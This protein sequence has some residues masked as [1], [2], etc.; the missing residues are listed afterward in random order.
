MEL[1][2]RTIREKSNLDKDPRPSVYNKDLSFMIL[3]VTT[4]PK[5]A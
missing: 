5:P 4:C 3:S 2:K 1:F